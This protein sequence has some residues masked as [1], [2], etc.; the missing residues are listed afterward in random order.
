MAGCGGKQVRRAVGGLLLLFALVGSALVCSLESW[1]D[2]RDV[3]VVATADSEF[4][5][6]PA[7][8]IS[9]N[10]RR[11]LYCVY[12]TLV[13][14]GARPGEVVPWLAQSW[15][16]DKDGKV[17]TFTLRQ[18]VSFHDGTPLSADKAA[19]SI[20][21]IWGISSVGNRGGGALQRTL[22]GERGRSLL[23]KVEVLSPLELR[24]TLRKPLADLLEILSHPAFSIAWVSSRREDGTPVLQGTGPYLVEDCRRGQ[25]LTLRRFERYWHHYPTWSRILLRTIRSASQR[26]VEVERD[27][28]DMAWSLCGSC[29]QN[30]R[31]GESCSLVKHPG[32]VYWRLALN[33]AQ[34]PFS[35]IRCRFGV[36]RGIPTDLLLE[37]CLAKDGCLASCCLP[38][39]SWA[40]AHSLTK[41]AYDPDKARSW[42]SKGVGKKPQEGLAQVELLYNAQACLDERVVHVV[43]ELVSN[44]QNMGVN[45]CGV[46]VSEREYRSRLA[47]GFYQMALLQTEQGD[48]DPDINLSMQWSG[49][50]E[51]DG[52]VSIENYSSER[53]WLALNEART[54]DDIEARRRAYARAFGLVQEGAP[55]LPL[56]WVPVYSAY[57]AQIKGVK[58]DRFNMFDIS[59]ASF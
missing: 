8:A 25:R 6:D 59:E 12:E 48:C 15:K 42:Y 10:S 5:M 26:A 2:S 35:D 46:G 16:C 27:H 20:K 54:T 14:P 28:V 4:E 43:Q 41:R 50:D 57:N 51:M 45:A 38:P 23:E 19:D 44:L 3:L 29:L 30:L 36:Q 17:W 18:G 21:R 39:T 33:C 1:A 53:L 11:V 13:R 40:V 37:R 9:T 22:L 52:L 47:T 49:G 24:L 34:P 32:Q 7:L 56:A 58:V 55:E 31:A